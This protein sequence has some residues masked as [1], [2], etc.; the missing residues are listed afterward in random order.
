MTITEVSK[1]YGLSA[2]TLRYYE[3]VGLIPRVNRNKSGIRDYTE[4]DCGWVEFIKCMRGAGLP[5]ETLIEYVDLFQQGPSTV[6]ARK[7]ILLEQRRLLLL[8]IEA[9]QNT[10]AR[11]NAKIEKYD[12]AAPT[13]V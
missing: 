13:G 5:V 7:E 8:R 4:K 11:L 2:D 3:R 1:T 10:L 6:G 9:M 12:Q